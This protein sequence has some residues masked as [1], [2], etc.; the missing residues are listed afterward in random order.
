MPTPGLVTRLRKL[1][2]GDI[3][4]ATQAGAPQPA[5][6]P[7]VATA[8][9]PSAPTAAAEVHAPSPAL[10]SGRPIVFTGRVKWTTGI[11]ISL[12]VGV[13]FYSTIVTYY[14]LDYHLET[15]EVAFT[16]I[17]T[18]FAFAAS[19]T[20]LRR[21]GKRPRLTVGVTGLTYELGRT[22]VTFAWYEFSSAEIRSGKLVAVTAPGSS[23]VLR[24]D[25]RGRF[26]ASRDGFVVCD[27][28]KVRATESQ[29]QQAI[30]RFAPRAGA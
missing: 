7:V 28:A 16:V 14:N 20:A 25:V 1:I 3:T 30:A 9:E 24:P 6:Q 23:L 22:A 11:M 12:V 18:L 17:F 8:P 26:D 4:P 19:V 10:P 27:I 15:S 29:V 13:V 5:L 2:E 21:R